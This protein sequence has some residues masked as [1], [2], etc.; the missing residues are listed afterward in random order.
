MSLA[1]AGA[2]RPSLR[3]TP[4]LPITLMWQSTAAATQLRC[5]GSMMARPTVSMRSD[6]SAG[7]AGAGQPQFN[8][9]APDGTFTD[10]TTQAGLNPHNGD[11][12]GVVWGDF[13]SD[14]KLDLHISKGS[15][16]IHNS[17]NFN[18][19]WHNNGNETFTNIA[20][21]AGVT[22]LGHRTRGS[23]GVDYDGDSKLDILATSFA[24]PSGG[25]TN[26]L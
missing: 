22:A 11:A 3:P 15:T 6:T 21:S 4:V 8:R 13:D 1:K 25:G 19:L 17:N 7:T 5:G 20:A 9:G 23:Y 24:R 12:D 16:K 10:V 26:L 2:L 18:E 14:G